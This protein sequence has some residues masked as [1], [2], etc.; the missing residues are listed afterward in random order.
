MV[1][2]ASG[3]AALNV[4]VLKSLSEIVC[5]EAILASNTSSIPI[6]EQATV[7][8][9]IAMSLLPLAIPTRPPASAPLRAIARVP[10]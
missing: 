1:D 5:D 2:A 4:Q 3:D 7:L 10:P 6:A 8:C 9:A